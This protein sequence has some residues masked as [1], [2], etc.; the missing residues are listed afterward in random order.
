MRSGQLEAASSPSVQPLGRK[1]K[2]KK[3]ASRRCG[4]ICCIRLDIGGCYR[5]GR[6]EARWALEEEPRD[7]VAISM[8]LAPHSGRA[9]ALRVTRARL[10][11]EED[12]RGPS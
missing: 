1:D 4:G 8:V 12:G 7:W 5:G 2:K 10:E 6:A 3:R 9:A 11:E